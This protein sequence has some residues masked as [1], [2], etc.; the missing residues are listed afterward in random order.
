MIL[1]ATTMQNSDIVDGVDYIFRESE[2][3]GRPC[4]VNLSLGDGIG[5]HDGTNFMDIMLDRMVGPGKIITVA[6]GNSRDMPVYTELMSPSDTLRTFVGRSNT[7]ISYG[8]VDIWA[9]EPGEPFSVCLDLYDSE[10]DEI[11]NTTGFFALDTMPKSSVF[12]S[13]S[14][15]GTL[16]YE[17]RMESELYVFNGRYRLFIQF[18]YP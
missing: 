5:G 6:M 16:V 3:Q 8:L 15:D 11:L 4:V 12:T 2:K 9:D 10:S 14:V 18:N 1:V 17:V 13:E 7:D